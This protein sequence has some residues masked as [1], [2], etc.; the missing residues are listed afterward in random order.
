MHAVKV[1]SIVWFF[2]F[3]FTACKENQIG[4]MDKSDDTPPGSV[5][6]VTVEN[7]PGAAVV[8]YDLPEDSDLLYVEAVYQINNETTREA[9][10]SL[11]NNSLSVVGFGDTLQ[12]DVKLYAVDRSENESEPVTVTVEP[13]TPPVVSVSQSLDVQDDFGG[14]NVAFH[15][16]NEADIVILAITKDDTGDWISAGDLYTSRREGDFNVRGFEAEPR[17]FGIYV[18]DR[19]KNYSDTLFVEATPLFEIELDKSRFQELQL[20]GDAEAFSGIWGMNNIW[21]DDII[22]AFV[23]S[24]DVEKGGGLPITVTM[25]LGIQVKLSRMKIWQR[26]GGNNQYLYQQSNYKH[27]EIWGSNNPAGDGSFDGWTKLTDFESFKPSGFPGGEFSNEDLEYAQAGEDVGF[28]T[29][30]PAVQYI[31][32]RV[33]ETWAAAPGSEG[34]NMSIGEV[35]FWG[36]EQDQ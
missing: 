2:L 21:N 25:D 7:L 10:S 30:A 28:P 5:T 11:F 29:D 14:I 1:F 16:E 15:N 13:L 20:P 18:R 27:V 36:Q 26:F 12:H 8:S 17:T 31:R 6:D 23:T 35:T 3:L 9:R 32:F 24:R 4:P 19:W 34:A 33:I 22:D